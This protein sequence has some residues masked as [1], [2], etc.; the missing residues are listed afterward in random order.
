MVTGRWEINTKKKLAVFIVI[1]LL[2]LALLT[3]MV[4]NSYAVLFWGEKILLKVVP[5]DPRSLFQGDYVRLGYSFSNLDLTKVQHDFDPQQIN[6]QEKLYLVLEKKA[7][8]WDVV[9]ATRDKNKVKGLTFIEAKMLY[10]SPGVLTEEQEKELKEKGIEPPSNILH[11]KLP[12]EQYYVPEGKGLEI[13]E[14][15]REGE[16]YAQVAVY[17]GKARVMDLIIDKL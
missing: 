5:V 16:V 17:K 9:L 15:I 14:R 3:V 10:F 7:Q 8:E 12:I 13:E 1:I 4:L 2:Q 11:L 6:Y